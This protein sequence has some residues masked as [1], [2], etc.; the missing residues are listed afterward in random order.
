MRLPYR[1]LLLSFTSYV[2][3]LQHLREAVSRD[4][5]LVVELLEAAYAQ[6]SPA[7]ALLCL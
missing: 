7:G 6:D 1:C 2:L 4:T 5:D 3:S